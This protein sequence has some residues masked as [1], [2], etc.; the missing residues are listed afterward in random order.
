MNLD[1]DV[2]LEA[3]LVVATLDAVPPT[4]LPADDDDE[5]KE[6]TTAVLDDLPAELLL[7]PGTA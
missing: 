6:A 1:D 7:E 2:S 4:A 5:E 3:A